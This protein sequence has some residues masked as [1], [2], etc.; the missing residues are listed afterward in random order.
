MP[1]PI[2]VT[3]VTG[4]LGAGK[5]TLVNGWLAGIL[6]GEIAV[7]VNEHGD[8]GIDGEL[9]AARARD[10]VEI[11]GGCVCCATQAELV[12][13]LDDFANAA[14]PPKRILVETS[15]AASPAGV[16]TAIARGGKTGAF[17]LDGILTV[18][19]AAR[20]DGLAAHD[21]AFE[22]LGYADIVVLSRADVC[23]LEELVHAREVVVARNPAA[24]LVE[25]AR[26]EISSIPSLQRL[27]DE[28]RADFVHRRRPGHARSSHAQSS[29]AQSSHAASHVYESISLTLEGD[30]DGERFAD[31]VEAQL[32]AISGRIF[33]TKGILAVAGVQERMIVQGVAD[34]LEVTFGEPWGEAPRTS[35]LVLVGFA[36]ERDSIERGF[37]ACAVSGTLLLTDG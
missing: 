9:L 1:L 10:L 36:L 12:R 16:V 14:L 5:T 26:G 6:R 19:D 17:E 11:T 13:A 28:R 37:A 4:F 24:L 25:A 29:H 32:G 8:V 34:S 35:R 18:V 21:L 22:Q 15:G 27:L 30:V 31:F 3:V 23:T 20:I 2:P 7:I 33:R